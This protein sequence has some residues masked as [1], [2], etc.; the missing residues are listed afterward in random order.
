MCR[1]VREFCVRKFTRRQ[2]GDKKSTINWEACDSVCGVAVFLTPPPLRF[3]CCIEEKGALCVVICC[4][5]WSPTDRPL[6]GQ[7]QFACRNMK[8]LY[9]FSFL[10][11]PF[12]ISIDLAV[13]YRLAH[14]LSYGGVVLILIFILPGGCLNFSAWF[15]KNV[16]F[17]EIK[18]KQ[19]NERHW[20]ES[21]TLCSIS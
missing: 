7:L 8:H 21:K 12:F 2:A 9:Y 20:V 15:M 17:E 1:K 11:T 18:I 16:L 19:C 14:L 5:S 3:T 6:W 4:R 10:C 13:P